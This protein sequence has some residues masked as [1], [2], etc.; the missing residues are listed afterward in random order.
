MKTNKT[1]IR[2]VYDNALAKEGQKKNFSG[3]LKASVYASWN[4]EKL[5]LTLISD[6]ASE[7]TVTLDGYEKTFVASGA[8]TTHV[9]NMKDTSVAF[10]DGGQT[11]PISITASSDK[12]SSVLSGIFMLCDEDLVFS[13]DKEN[14]RKLLGNIT[15]RAV[16]NPEMD[17]DVTDFGVAE[18]ENGFQIYDRFNENSP[19][20]PHTVIDVESSDIDRFD[21]FDR[22]GKDMSINMTVCIDSFPMMDYMAVRGTESAYGLSFIL[23][24]EGGERAPFFGFQRSEAGMYMYVNGGTPQ[25][26]YICDHVKL[27][28]PFELSVKIYQNNGSTGKYWALSGSSLVECIDEAGHA[29]RFTSSTEGHKAK[30]ARLQREEE[31]RQ[32]QAELERMQREEE[33]E[34]ARQES[35]LGILKALPTDKFNKLMKL[36]N[37]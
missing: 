31:E 25:T 27:S 35:Q 9:I 10:R 34:Q 37:G 24:G 15:R 13:L 30:Q 33:A 22:N 23:C 16:I 28:V 1:V 29:I 17:P 6:E 8:V 21:G 14:T 19:N 26:A 18:C 3:E 11:F 7:Y 12:T 2:A 20:F 4:S 36:L 5:S 32:R